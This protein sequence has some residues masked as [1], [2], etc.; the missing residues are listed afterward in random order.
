MFSESGVTIRW[1]I[2]LPSDEVARTLANISC[3]SFSWPP[4]IIHRIHF[5][6]DLYLKII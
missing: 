1:A 2:R 4:N 5:A 3:A 6:N